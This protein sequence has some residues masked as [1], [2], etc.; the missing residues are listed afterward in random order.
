MLSRFETPSWSWI[1]EGLLPYALAAMRALWIWTLIHLWAMFIGTDDLLSL[2]EVFLLLAGSTLAAQV[3]I[4]ILRSPVSAALLVVLGGLGSVLALIYLRYGL[5]GGAFWEFSW[6][7]RL[8]DDPLPVMATVPVAGYAWWWGIHAG[9]QRVYY[10]TYLR[11]FTA[12]LAALGLAL[13][14]SYASA[15]LDPSLATTSLMLFFALGMATLSIA[16]VQQARSMERSRGQ[17]S[18]VLSRYW[19]VSVA[20]VI[21]ALLLAGVLLS[22]IFVPGV[23][24]RLQAA[25]NLVFGILGRIL[26]VIFLVLSYPLVWLLSKLVEAIQANTEY[27]PPEGF[28]QQRPLEEQLEQVEQSVATLSPQAA[29]LLRIGLIVVLVLGIALIFL[30]AFRYFSST[31]EDEDVEETRELILSGEL[32]RDQLSGWL[33]GRRRRSVAEPPPFAVVGGEDARAQIRRTY[34]ELLRWAG[35]QGLP[36]RPGQTPGEYAAR[37]RGELPRYAEH[38]AAI[39]AAYQHA[40]YS[41]GPIPPAAGEQATAAW[42]AIVAAERAGVA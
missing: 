22:Q 24:D 41:T 15:V 33:R 40:R 34:Q 1:D 7:L 32:L 30:L 28:L 5:A 4:H 19:L 16:G 8:A 14:L 26:L 37:M 31:R 20:V 13:G 23:V 9:R 36:R 10:E 42:A 11:N 39:T 6:I 38:I 25:V 18:I 27:R 17:Q 35:E 21:V 2:L 12:G 29:T 3:G